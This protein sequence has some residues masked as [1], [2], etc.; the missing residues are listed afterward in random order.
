MPWNHY[1]HETFLVW[2]VNEM[3]GLVYPQWTI[4]KT[5]LASIVALMV[6]IVVGSLIAVPLVVES[7]IVLPVQAMIVN[8]LILNVRSA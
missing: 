8:L 5:T 7:L 4:L 3:Q 2:Y 6:V 1:G